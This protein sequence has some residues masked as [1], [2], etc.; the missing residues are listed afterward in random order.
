VKEEEEESARSRQLKAKLISQKVL[1]FGLAC[2]K[3]E[4]RP[5]KKTY[6]AS[7]E[8][9]HDYGRGIKTNVVD[10]DA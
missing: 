1:A 8:D 10:K 9:G 7:L 5:P 6:N 4:L 3:G 2:H